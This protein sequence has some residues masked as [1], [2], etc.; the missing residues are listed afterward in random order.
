MNTDIKKLFRTF[1]TENHAPGSNAPGS[2]VTALNK[3]DTALHQHNIILSPDES[4]WEIRD[5]ERLLNLH[6]FILGEQ[7]KVDGGIFCNEP[8]PSYWQNSFCSA[9][10]KDFTKFLTL[11]AH[12]KEI[13]KHFNETNNAEQLIEKI[14]EVQIT[15]NKSLIDDNISLNSLE[16]KTQLR[17]VEIRQNQ[18]VFRNMILNIYQNQCCITG[19]PVKEVLRASHI[20][21]WANDKK[22]RMNPENGLCLS[23]TY[24]A[25]FDRHLISLDENYRLILSPALKEYCTN[26]A[27]KKYFEN[28][29]GKAITLPTRFLPSQVLLE[30]HRKKL[31]RG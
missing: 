27:Y 9:A 3:I 24:D 17:E 4:V 25:A 19:L 7:K 28:F 18:N 31:V 23:A 2:Y 14:K 15:P 16:G 13:F 12:Q 20:S 30:K 1:A 6:Q 26:E 8:S 11:S 5:I 29:Y 21:A 10:I 22:N